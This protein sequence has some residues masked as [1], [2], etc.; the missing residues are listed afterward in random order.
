MGQLED[1]LKHQNMV[2]NN[3]MKSFGVEIS[4]DSLEKS[5]EDEVNPFEMEAYKSELTKAELDE[6]EKAKHQDGDMHPNGKWVW[7][8]SANGGKGDWR[9]A[10]PSRG[11]GSKATTGGA[12]ANAD[13]TSKPKGNAKST[14]D[15]DSLIYAKDQL[16]VNKFWENVLTSNSGKGKN[17][18]GK[19]LSSMK[20]YGYSHVSGTM[21]AN[22]MTTFKFYNKDA[23]KNITMVPYQDAL[24]IKTSDKREALEVSN[25]KAI[26]DF[27]K[28]FDETVLKLSGKDNDAKKKSAKSNTYITPDNA[29]EYVQK[30]NKVLDRKGY[31]AHATKSGS[32]E[33]YKKGDRKALKNLKASI[34]ATDYI[35]WG[36]NK[37]LKDKL[38]PVIKEALSSSASDA[39]KKDDKEIPNAAQASISNI[40][41]KT[42]GKNLSSLKFKGKKVIINVDGKAYGSGYSSYVKSSYKDGKWTGSETANSS[43]KSSIDDVEKKLGTLIKYVNQIELTE[44]YD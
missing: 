27:K 28:K 34:I 37:E 16:E 7:R 39:N 25:F 33:I 44:N 22:G 12:A 19:L 5:F 13:T 2:R 30:L 24:V 3:I 38:E 11:G 15:F 41:R 21:L 18:A 29:D 43:D 6:F 4:E 23:D 10:K 17:L 1:I 14:S 40:I 42:F 20:E 35:N 9:V 31:F 8:Q 32:I 26:A 36:P